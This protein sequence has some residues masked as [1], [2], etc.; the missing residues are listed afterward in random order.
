MVRGRSRARTVIDFRQCRR[1]RNSCDWSAGPTTH[2][3]KLLLLILKR[4]N[5]V[6]PPC[7]TSSL[8]SSNIPNQSALF[9]I[10]PRKVSNFSCL[11]RFMSTL[12][13][14]D[15]VFLIRN[16]QVTPSPL[17]SY[18]LRLCMILSFTTPPLPPPTRRSSTAYGHACC[19]DY[20]SL[21]P[22]P[23]DI[24]W[25]SAASCVL[26]ARDEI[27][28]IFCIRYA[29]GNIPRGGTPRNQI[30]NTFEFQVFASTGGRPF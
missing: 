15:Y 13:G 17:L 16:N 8:Q 6:P 25:L 1:P 12:P 30:C 20:T 29:A 2:T 3:R 26:R 23:V 14:L 18:R 5:K 11:C 10:Y 24:A 7:D 21:R 19:E 28:L 9:T 27:A 4:T 22:L